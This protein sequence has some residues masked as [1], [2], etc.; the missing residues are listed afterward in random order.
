MYMSP[1]EN[2]KWDFD[3][4][5]I[6]GSGFPIMSGEKI[7]I[8]M[9]NESRNRIRLWDMRVYFRDKVYWEFHNIDLSRVSNIT[10]NVDGRFRKILSTIKNSGR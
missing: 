5:E 8:T 3:V 10:L 2:G 1:S 6:S 9:R 7:N 4:D